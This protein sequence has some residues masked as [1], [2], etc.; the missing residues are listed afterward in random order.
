MRTLVAAGLAALACAFLAAPA[1]A[2]PNTY[3]ILGSCN[4]TCA[5]VGLSR[6]INAIGRLTI[7]RDTIVLGGTFDQTDLVSYSLSFGSST[8]SNANAVGA[9][10]T[11]VWGSDLDT[12]AALDLRASTALAPSTGLGLV[13][14]L[15]GSI[16]STDATCPT[17][18][19][20]T[21]SFNSLA[22]LS[23]VTVTALPGPLPPAPVPLPPAL[24]LA[25]AGLGCLA[26][27][28]RARGRA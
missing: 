22:T 20:Q 6:G 24:G 10:L 3:S 4:G 23:G 14:M 2:A 7:N 25:L 16:I 26:L 28:R 17:A 1:G 27:A 13:L 19:C 9:S 12:I 8:I 5:N 11:G 21:V 18:A 15:G